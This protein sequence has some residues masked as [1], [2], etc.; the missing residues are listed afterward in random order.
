[1]NLLRND[2]LEAAYATSR[3]NL[4]SYLTR[5]VVR[6]E[7]AEE[8]VHDA[9]ERLLAQA[10]APATPQEVRAWLFKVGSRLAIDHLRRHA[11]WRETV[12]LEA[13][14][15]AV[16]DESFV[17]ESRSLCG[18]PEMA[19]IAREHLAMCLSCTLRSVRAPRARSPPG[20]PAG[21]R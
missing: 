6:P 9:I 10:E 17:A 15:L 18:Q 20:W 5:L 19:S 8:L 11:T 16:E 4:K 14:E 1:M 21:W 3:R 12:L 2:A 7:V 13:R